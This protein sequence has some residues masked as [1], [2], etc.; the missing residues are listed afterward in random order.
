MARYGIMARKLPGKLPYSHAVAIRGAVLLSADS[1]SVFYQGT[2]YD[3][4]PRE[5]APKTFIDKVNIRTGAKERIYESGND[6]VSERVTS[7][8]DIDA[9]KF[10][11]CV[12]LFARVSED[13]SPFHDAL[14]KYFA[15][16]GDQATL[17]IL[18]RGR[19]DAAATER[20]LSRADRC[21]ILLELVLLAAFFVTV[22][23]GGFLMG[24]QVSGVSDEV[25]PRTLGQSEP[26]ANPG[27]REVAPGEYEA[28]VVAQAW[29]FNPRV[30]EVPVG[31][32]VTIYVTSSDL[33]H[34]FKV[35]DTNINMQIVPGQV[36]K[37]V[38]TFDTV[39]EF[40]YLC[41]EYCGTGHATMYGTV[42]VVADI[43]TSGSGSNGS[44][45]TAAN[46]SS[47]STTEASR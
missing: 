16:A 29:T 46:S 8:L 17:A 12:T 41:T 23:I 31:S 39:G 45:T 33:Q 22:T 24:F 9:K 32:T 6:G 10:H 11:S 15:G 36:S 19:D 20:K 25:D 38:Y 28:Y 40:P 14:V 47:G 4:N 26:W 5:T 3:R 34:G 35:T 37:L 2:L 1:T 7:V 18:A 43:G 44:A 21:F 30:L 27:L 13:A 42:K